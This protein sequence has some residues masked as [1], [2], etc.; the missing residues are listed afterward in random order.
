MHKSICI[1][2]TNEADTCRVCGRKLVRARV[3]SAPLLLREAT[4]EQLKEWPR[5]PV[6]IRDDAFGTTTFHG[7][8]FAENQYA[9]VDSADKGLDKYM[10]SW[11]DNTNIG[12]GHFCSVGCAVAFARIA[13]NAGLRLPSVTPKQRRELRRNHRVIQALC[14]EVLQPSPREVPPEETIRATG[15]L[16]PRGRSSKYRGVGPEVWVYRDGKLRRNKWDNGVVAAR[17]EDRTAPI[18][19]NLKPPKDGY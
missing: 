16:T 19:K 6:F 7:M 9:Y 17:V 10:G 2:P 13:A 4:A 12:D 15:R 3:F 11:R 18:P 5:N 8:Y 14:P 1:A